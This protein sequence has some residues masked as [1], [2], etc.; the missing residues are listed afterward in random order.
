VGLALRFQFLQGTYQAAEP[1]QI[2][3]PEWPLHPVRVHCALVAAGWAMAGDGLFPESTVLAALRWLESAGAPTIALPAN[4]ARRISP[5]VYVPRNPTREEL[6]DAQA[7]LR[8]GDHRA[9]QRQ[10]GRVDRTFPTIVLGD[11]PVWL[12]WPHSEPNLELGSVFEALADYV[13]YLGSSRSPVACAAVDS[14]D[15]PEPTLVPV[16]RTGSYVLRVASAGLTDELVRN[17]YDWGG[18]GGAAQ[19]YRHAW[20]AAGHAEAVG[21]PPLSG[22]FTRLVVLQRVKG[23]RLT[24][25]HTAIVTR[26]LRDAVLANAGDDAPAILH[27]HGRNPHVAF[28]PLASVGNRYAGGEIRGFALAIPNGATDEEEAAIV[29]AVRRTKRV[30]ITREIVPWR[31]EHLP[32]PAML[33]EPD[34]DSALRTLDPGRWLGPADSW[35]TATPVVLDR[36]TRPGRRQSAVDM[37][38]LAFDNAL[39][40]QPLSVEISKAPFLG[41]AVPVGVHAANGAPRGALWHVRARFERPLRGPVIVGRG[42]Y[43]GTGLFAPAPGPLEEP[44]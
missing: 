36:H 1:G 15:A 27:G 28:L 39:L 33:A 26:A 34:P 2:T 42:R 32:D 7:S 37:V 41:G 19:P 30:A 23:F 6:S 24:L 16:D 3:E 8:R 43:M 12:A 13:G 44:R 25:A 17:R 35:A 10:F 9:F 31:V 22:P 38:M 11:E 14:R 20:R 21:E 4:V 5:T 18:I 40:P 29:K